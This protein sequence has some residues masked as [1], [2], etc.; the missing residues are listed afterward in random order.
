M[1]SAAEKKPLLKPQL[2]AAIDFVGGITLAN[3]L[4]VIRH[5]GAVACSGLVQSTDAAD[6]RISF[7]L[8]WCKFAGYRFG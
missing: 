1:F 2:D 3:V 6:Q 5:S 7:Y 8:A 4:K